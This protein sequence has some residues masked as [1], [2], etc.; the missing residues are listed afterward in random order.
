MITSS[1]WLLQFCTQ[2]RTN[3]DDLCVSMNT[4]NLNFSLTLGCYE[5][6][7]LLI[8]LFLCWSALA[9][10]VFPSKQTH[11]ASL[12]LA[13]PLPQI[14]RLL[15]PLPL[16]SFHFLHFSFIYSSFTLLRCFLSPPISLPFSWLTTIS[17][18]VAKVIWQPPQSTFVFPS[19]Q[20][21]KTLCYSNGLQKRESF[22]LV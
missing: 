4:L 7:L 5:G 10:S 20:L 8:H 14:F 21:K 3:T 1:C 18:A 2:D 12:L 11:I 9:Q 19:L 13:K 15:S 22:E 17:I 6:A 16:P